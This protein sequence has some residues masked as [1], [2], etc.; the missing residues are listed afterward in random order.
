VF[1]E[2][3]KKVFYSKFMFEP[4]PVES[5]LHMQLA[6]HI[7]ADISSSQIQSTEDALNF[8]S[9]T[10]LAQRVKA[11]PLY[12]I[13]EFVGNLSGDESEPELPS[14]DEYFLRLTE[15][16]FME[17]EE[18]KCVE[19][20]KTSSNHFKVQGTRIGE[21]CSFYYLNHLTVRTFSRLRTMENSLNDII[22]L[23][24]DASEFKE[25][26]IRHNEDKILE[27]LHGKVLFINP[28][29]TYAEANQKVLMMIQMY[30]LRVEWPMTDFETDFATLMDQALRM[31]PAM[32]DMSLYFGNFDAVSGI[33]LLMQLLVN[34]TWKT[35]ST[36]RIFSDLTGKDTVNSLESLGVKSLMQLQDSRNIQDEVI[37]QQLKLVPHPYYII[38]R[39]GENVSIRFGLK[40]YSTGV[41]IVKFDDCR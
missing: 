6:N 28:L 11:N 27:S 37:K 5:S 20:L 32:V 30:L 3:S 1:I 36:L 40:S 17:L 34:R 13:S 41:K 15:R 29:L 23:L 10:F 38:K 25:F 21:I 39:T 31:L 19:L 24:S 22:T 18:S 7:N 14:V 2:E 16:C 8:L 33:Y 4:F 12:Y 35:Q 26:P 9:W